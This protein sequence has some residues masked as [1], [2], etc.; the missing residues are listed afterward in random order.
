MAG[1]HQ[2][3]ELEVTARRVLRGETDV[4][5]DDRDL[6]LLDDQHGHFFHTQQEGVEVVRAVEQGVVLESD[7]AAQVEELLKILIRAVLVVLVAK[8]GFD[9]PRITGGTEPGRRFQRFDVLESTEAAR[10]V[11]TRQF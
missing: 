2:A 5:L 8:N 10:N 6:A 1:P 3:P 4:R 11:A 9:E 7:L